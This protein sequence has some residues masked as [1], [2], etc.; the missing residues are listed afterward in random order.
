MKRTVLLI[1]TIILGMVLLQGCETVKG[2]QTGAK[3]DVENT[4]SH[5][6]NGVNAML[7]ADRRF[8]EKYW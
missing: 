6:Q 3:K 8:Q 4:G 1:P 7:E 5:L 2:A